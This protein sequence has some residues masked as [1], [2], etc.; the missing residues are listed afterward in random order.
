MI[1][2]VEQTLQKPLVLVGMMGSGKSHV[3]RDLSV[4]LELDFYDSD[5]EIER[6][7]GKTISQIFEED[8]EAYFRSVEY[9]VIQRLF[10]KGACIIS[11]GGGA[12]TSV[13]SLALIRKN[14]VSVWI[15]AGLDVL[16]ARVQNDTGRPLLQKDNPKQVLEDI[17]TA[18][19]DLYKQ[20]DIHVSN[21]DPNTQGVVKDIID[22]IKKNN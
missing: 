1:K 16:W 14:A 3:G 10:Q 22:Q 9:E 5:Q 17:L 2:P 7:Q 18:R 4:A 13:Q 21:N 6:K 11:S 8:G 20:A 19:L 12:V 15:Q